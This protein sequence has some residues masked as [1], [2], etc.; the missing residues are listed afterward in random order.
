M[1]IVIGI[2]LKILYILPY[3]GLGVYV[4]RIL[5]LKT[6][7]VHVPKGKK[8]T[9]ELLESCISQLRKE[10]K[11]VHN[12]YIVDESIMDELNKNNRDPK[13]I[14]RLLNDIAEHVNMNGDLF[15]I[16]VND[17]IVTDRA[18]DIRP[19]VANI[20]IN[21][22]MKDE[23]DTDTIISVLAHEVM[24][25]YLYFQGIKRRDAWENEIL[26]DTA[27]V[28]CGYYE[29]MKRGY[30]IKHGIN[31]FS[32]TKVGYISVKDIEY[33]KNRIENDY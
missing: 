17:A 29:Y 26:T 15:V 20:K 5:I 31:P 9:N 25:Q 18:G 6:T 10:D 13:F 2:L 3:I 11:N 19:G 22:E 16:N 33:I 21:L 23:Y 7:K 12:R 4:I 32:Y 8:L 27:V 28:Y 1:N 24:H 30:D 14:K